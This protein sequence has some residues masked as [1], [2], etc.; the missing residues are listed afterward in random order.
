MTER[1]IQAFIQSAW[2]CH[3]MHRESIANCSNLE[4]HRRYLISFHYYRTTE[5]KNSQFIFYIDINYRSI[6]Q[7][8]LT[9][10]RLNCKLDRWTLNLIRSYS[11]RLGSRFTWNH[12]ARIL[13]RGIVL[14]YEILHW[15]RNI[16]ATITGICYSIEILS[17]W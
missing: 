2:Q 10:T 12:A 15:E 8:A 7:C 17:L 6:Y 1:W 5:K 3:S 16:V 14:A 11:T 9:D 13:T 4:K